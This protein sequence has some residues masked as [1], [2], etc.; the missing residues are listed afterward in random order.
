[1]SKC[2][3]SFYFC[4][5]MD[6]DS[7]SV[8]PYIKHAKKELCQYP[9]ILTSCSVNNPHIPLFRSM[10]ATHIVKM[11]LEAK[12]LKIAQLMSVLSLSFQ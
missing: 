12:S 9:D 5:F 2:W 11:R 8:R 6:L 7:V 3:P 4:L 10:P 1:M